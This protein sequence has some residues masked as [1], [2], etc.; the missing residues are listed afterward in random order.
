[1]NGTVEKVT[2]GCGWIAGPVLLF[3]WASQGTANAQ[4]ETNLT[5]HSGAS[6]A[7]Y[8][9]ISKPGEITMPINVWGHVR[10]P[11]RYEVPISTD[12]IQ[13]LS[14]A[15][16]PMP[17]ARLSA[18]KIS[19]IVRR[20]DEFRTVEFTVNLEHLDKLD[21]KARDLESGDTVFMDT[22][23]SF[24]EIFTYVTTLAIVAASVANV[25]ISLSYVR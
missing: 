20:E 15:G 4:V 5:S 2:R 10:N 19:R 22:S 13:L 12:L 21:E 24:G 17:E 8:Y 3:L 11:G 6:S 18:V 1:M 25:A 16:G 7:A 14:F 9:Y 23:V